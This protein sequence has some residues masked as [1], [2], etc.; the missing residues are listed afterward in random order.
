MSDN[1]QII[2]GDDAERAALDAERRAARAS[3]T[4]EKPDHALAR[5]MAERFR[6]FGAEGISAE[7]AFGG[8][9]GGEPPSNDDTASMPDEDPLDGLLERAIADKSVVFLP[10]VLE[11]LSAFE[12]ENKAAFE[13]LLS[14]LKSEAKV[15]LVELRKSITKTGQRIL[16]EREARRQEEGRKHRQQR[17]EEQREA[18]SRARE[19]CPEEFQPHFAFFEG[20][21]V[22]YAMAPGHLHARIETDTGNSRTVTLAYFSARIASETRHIDAVSESSIYDI[23]IIADNKMHR[24]RVPAEEFASMKWTALAGAEAALGAG[25]RARDEA[26]AAIQVLSKPVPKKVE[27]GMLGWRKLDGQNVFVHAGGLIG[28]PENMAAAVRLSD[29]IGNIGQLALPA[30]LSGEDLKHGVLQCLQVMTAHPAITIPLCIAPWRAVLGENR[31]TLFV[32]GTQKIGKS[33]AVMW[34]QN[35]FG[36]KFSVKN[37]PIEWSSTAFGIRAALAAAGDMPLLVDD[38]RP[39]HDPNQERVFGDIVRSV[40]GGNSRAKGTIRSTLVQDPIPRALLLATGEERPKKESVV[41]RTVMMKIRER[42]PLDAGEVEEYNEWA[43]EGRFAATM[44]AYIAWLAEGDRLAKVRKRFAE[45]AAELERRVSK[46]TNEGRTA[47]AVASLWAGVLPFLG[48]ACEV[49]GAITDDE[50]KDA[51]AVI[52]QTMTELAAEQI[53]QQES[54][55]IVARFFRYLSSAISSG[56]AHLTDRYHRAP[57]DPGAW[58]WVLSDSEQGQQSRRG[59]NG[60]EVPLEP[61]FRPGGTRV[62]VHLGDNVQLDRAAAVSV[63]QRMCKELEEPF[64]IDIDG[65]TDQLYQRG[66]LVKVSGDPS[67]PRSRTV[68]VMQSTHPGGKGVQLSGLV[69][70]TALLRGET[71]QPPTSLQGPELSE[72]DFSGDT[73]GE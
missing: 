28:A 67:N 19:E 29:K 46:S 41:S 71:I 15:G 69:V 31:V 35:H 42:L 61:R 26:R 5:E 1:T 13:Q 43:R 23:E 10:A 24:V 56:R 6:S 39:K 44:A 17:A 40:H 73:L 22:K 72:G 68:R 34:A 16:D 21:D 70:R 65:L 18:A 45:H 58:G 51:L 2:E 48:W 20:E 30:A 57:P 53:Q 62:G 38:Y 33:T 54:E 8:G 47:S 37:T 52:E 55:D 63:V 59:P 11:S 50:R 25:A 36:T 12:L 9:G 27:F 64:A 66:L 4:K 32:Y 3:A 7:G 14:R 49:V 60:E